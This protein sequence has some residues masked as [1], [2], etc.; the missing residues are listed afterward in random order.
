MDHRGQLVGV[1]G[2]EGAA[3]DLLPP[4][5]AVS[6]RPASAKGLP[7]LGTKR[8]GGLCRELVGEKDYR[9][10]IKK[11]KAEK[12]PLMILMTATWCG[13]CKLLEK[14]TL[15]DPWVRYFLSDFVVV[16]SCE[17]K[18]VENAYGLTTYPTLVFT[19]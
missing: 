3:V 19:D 8:K 9:S 18:D 13:P 16:K 6:H 11:A 10:E 14:E 4:S 2:Q 12:K 1:R 7:S 17:D 15:D 5:S